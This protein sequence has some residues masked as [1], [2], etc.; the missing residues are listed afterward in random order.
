M[1]ETSRNND[2]IKD[3]DL[4]LYLRDEKQ[5]QGTNVNRQISQTLNGY[6]KHEYRE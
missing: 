3:H 6:V 1:M 5:P 4:V 2:R